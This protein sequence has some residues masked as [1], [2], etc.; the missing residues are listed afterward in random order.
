MTTKSHKV[1]VFVDGERYIAVERDGTIKMSRG[2]GKDL[3]TATWRE[4]QMILTTGV[5]PDSACLALEKEIKK[6]MDNNW[7][8]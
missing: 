8:D 4:D 7:E 6:Q 3:G 2:D 1:E 5:L